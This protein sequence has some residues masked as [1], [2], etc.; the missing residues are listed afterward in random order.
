MPS[1]TPRTDK[2]ATRPEYGAGAVGEFVSAEFAHSLERALARAE[3]QIKW[4]EDNSALHK[5]VEILYVVDGYEVTVMHEDGVTEL[6]ARFR[7]ATLGEAIDAALSE[8][9]KR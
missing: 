8:G 1:D 4:L 9:G 7:G 5:M 2:E 6:S 3:G